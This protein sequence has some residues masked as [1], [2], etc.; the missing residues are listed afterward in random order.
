M[1]KQAIKSGVIQFGI[2]LQLE[3]VKLMKKLT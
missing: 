3:M 1:F 2:P